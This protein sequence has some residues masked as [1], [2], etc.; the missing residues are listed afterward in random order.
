MKLVEFQEIKLPKKL[1]IIN[2]VVFL[3]SAINYFPILFLF[4]LLLMT[5][6]KKL[7][8]PNFELKFRMFDWTF[9]KLV[10]LTKL[11]NQKIDF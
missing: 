8:H 9:L 7:T 5:G 4:A 3:K 11:N 6:M 2:V 10:E 1:T